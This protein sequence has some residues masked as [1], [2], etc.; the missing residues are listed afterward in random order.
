MT[1]SPTRAQSETLGVVLLLAV[2]L[3]GTGLIVTFGSSML[4]DSKRA[5]ELDSAEH[6]MTQFDSKA[7]LVGI[8]D[9]N[10][11]EVHLGVEDDGRTLLRSNDGWMRVEIDPDDGSK[12]EVRTRH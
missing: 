4:D 8:G 12:V 6:A 5:T 1:I 10:T 2:T 9:T 3:A 11:Q 7:S